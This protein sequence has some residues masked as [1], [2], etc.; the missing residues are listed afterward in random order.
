MTKKTSIKKQLIASIVAIALCF[1][2]LIG[3]TFAWFTDSVTSSGNVIKT[4]KL[5]VELYY[6]EGTED[7]ANA[8]WNNANGVAV[9]KA[10][11]LWEPGYTD[12]KHFK[13][14]N[15][16]T[17]ALKYQL[18]II[19]TGEVSELAEV[20]QVYLYEIADTDANATQIADRDDVDEGMYVGTL[21]EVIKRGIKQ[22]S[23]EA[24]CDYTTTI[25]FK[26]DK[27]AGNEY[28]EKSIGDDFKIQL[29]ATQYTS[30]DDSWGNDYDADAWIEGMLVYNESDLQAA[31]NAGEDVSLMNDIVVTNPI[32]IPA[33]AATTYSMR[34]ANAT[35]IN[36]NG[37]TLSTEG[38]TVIRNEGNLVIVGE[39]KITSV[40]G[41]AIRVQQGS[42]VIDTDD[43]EVSSD[44]GAVS[45]FNGANVTINGGNYFNRGYNGK[46]SH[47]I[48]LG[49]YGTININGGTFD[50]GYSNGGIDTVCGY[51]WENDANEKAVININGGTFYPS[52]LNSSYYFISNY[53][54]SWTEININGGVFHKYDPSKIGGTKFNADCAV[55]GN[56]GKYYVVSKDITMVFNAEQLQKAI[57]EDK[58]QILIGADITG[59]VTVA[60]KANVK[61]AIDGNGK[62][63]AGVITVDGKSATYTT[64]GL[65]ISD[66]T[67]KADSISA[68]ACVRLGD[69]TNDTRYT[70]NVSVVG[71]TFDVPGAVGVKSYTGGDKNLVI[72][73]C[74]VTANA[75][76]LIQAKGIDGVSIKGCE[77]YSKNGMNFNNS[78]N[79]IV[80]EC[81]VDV[82]GYAVRFGESSGGS[83][84]AEVYTIKNSTLKSANDDGDATI[85]LRGTADNSTL[86]IENTEING[87]LKIADTASNATIYLD[88]GVIVNTTA[89]LQAAVEAGTAEISL[90]DGEYDV[91]L[92]IVNANRNLTITGQGA[93]TTLNFKKGQVRLQQFDSLTISNC[94]IGRMVDKKWGQLVFSTS[95]NANGVYTISDCIFNGIG[96][97]G[98]YINEDTSGATYNIKNCTFNGDF[99][100]EGAITIQDNAGVKAT[101][102]VTECEFNNIP[103]TS[104]EIYFIFASGD[105][106]LNAEGIVPAAKN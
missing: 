64:A 74:V 93:A 85:I 104:N 23:L 21:A 51:G 81:T 9:Y 58:E 105:L 78:T 50:S 4:G 96:T 36:L 53:A 90:L 25:V 63:F 92:Y 47:T 57:N 2:S 11:Q 40:S 48:Y 97:Q 27:D 77:V 91:D 19:P 38:S 98:V 106:I 41:Y 33:P 42:M 13:I 60:Q 10:A 72:E 94:T 89:E 70:C 100:G 31:I 56:D 52:E 62:T 87:E 14:A 84:A 80:D 45:V 26:M 99:G 49:G 29:L 37:K 71:C 17:L 75:H 79:V 73:D 43:I 12:A 69:G 5:D 20:I 66:L 22:G 28:Q 95:D 7:P 68:D 76:S 32:I 15:E 83:G 55:F 101:V 1:T 39:G 44:F 103:E 82:K 24:G 3:T 8:N 34:A 61:V 86:T 18:A 59:D 88:G 46:T 30:E 67:F 35:V 54:G 16:G 102:N 65:T 6:A